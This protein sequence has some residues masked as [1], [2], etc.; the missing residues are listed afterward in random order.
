MVRLWKT[1]SHNLDELN[2]EG[3]SRGS[4]Q[5]IAINKS[6]KNFSSFKK[7]AIKG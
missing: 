2:E 4:P 1:E 6:I 3:I 7:E 5:N